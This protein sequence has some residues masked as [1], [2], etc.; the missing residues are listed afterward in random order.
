LV[1]CHSAL[2]LRAQGNPKILTAWISGSYNIKG[3]VLLSRTN[4]FSFFSELIGEKQHVGSRHTNGRFA[5][6]HAFCFH[7]DKGRK[8]LKNFSY[9]K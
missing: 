7:S 1:K 9:Y 6:M 2:I 3:R 8:S 4:G 5:L